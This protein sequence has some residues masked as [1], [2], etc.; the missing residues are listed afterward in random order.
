MVPLAYTVMP[1]PLGPLWLAAT[2]RG[3][4]A[5]EMG[6]EEDAVLAAWRRRLGG[7]PARDD[8]ALRPYVQELERYFAG[9]LSRFQAPLDPLEGTPFQR[10]VWRALATIPHGETRSYKWLAQQVDQPRGFRAVGMA[11]ARNPLPIVV[12]CHRVVNAD[13]QLGGYGGGLERKRAL[14]RLEGALPPDGLPAS[15]TIVR[16]PLSAAAPECP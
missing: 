9:A 15:T 10:R 12:P 14:L 7:A 4:A 13:G 11:N 1:S 5:V 16:K 6:G 3:L 8:A 2:P